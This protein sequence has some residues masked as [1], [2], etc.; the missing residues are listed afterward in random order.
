[1]TFKNSIKTP[2]ALPVLNMTPGDGAY[3]LVRKDGKTYRVPMGVMP[4]A[5]AMAAAAAAEAFAQT[6]H[7]HD[8][9]GV[10]GLAAALAGKEPSIAPAAAGKYLRGD[11]NWGNF[12]HDV[13][14]AMATSSP[15]NDDLNQVVTSG[16][17]RLGGTVANGPGGCEWG[18]LIMSRGA[19]T[20]FQI[21]TG[22]NN[23]RFYMRHGSGGLGVITTWLPWQEVM[24]TDGDSRLRQQRKA[25]IPLFAG[26]NNMTLTAGRAY[27]VY[28]WDGAKTL[29][30]PAVANTQTGDE[31]ELVNLHMGWGPG[32]SGNAFVIAQSAGTSINNFSGDVSIN[33][34]C[35]GIRLKCGWADGVSASWGVMR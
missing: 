29:Y 34:H 6:S 33:V 30:M 19:D 16:F 35:G 12:A 21:V 9:A 8:I 27:A 26:N 7:T 14:D 22:Y 17:Y 11:K 18:Q 28:L 25:M 24:T 2:D 5:N 20:A 31:I 23:N 15:P 32:G 3:T 10:S 4:G 1:M 13:R